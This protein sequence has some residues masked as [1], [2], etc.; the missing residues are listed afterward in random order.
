MSF[1][2]ARELAAFH[3]EC[4]AG[5]GRCLTS[6][7]PTSGA[8]IFSR[9]ARV[10]RKYINQPVLKRRIDGLAA[11]KIGCVDYDI[12]APTLRADPSLPLRLQTILRIIIA[13]HE[14]SRWIEQASSSSDLVQDCLSACRN[15][16]RWKRGYLSNSGQEQFAD[17]SLRGIVGQER[18]RIVDKKCVDSSERFRRSNLR[19]A[20]E[21]LHEHAS[22]LGLPIRS[23]A[24]AFRNWN[25]GY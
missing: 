17:D 21:K 8:D 5:T 18:V 12:P 4:D 16:G 11:C 19:W 13:L 23:L 7:A 6:P 9:E 10:S 14:V 25:Y 1:D 3:A 15:C 22:F 2:H 24:S 20:R